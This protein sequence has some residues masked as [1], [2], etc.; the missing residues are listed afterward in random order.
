MGFGKKLSTLI[1]ATLRGGFSGRRKRPRHV[2][3]DPESQLKAIRKALAEVELKERQVGDQLQATQTRLNQAIE[4]GDQAEVTAQRRLLHQLESH[5][6]TQ[7][8][9]AVRLAESLAV[10]EDH[11]ATE[12]RE[13]AERIAA[14][15]EVRDRSAPPQ[16]SVA[17]AQSI[18]G[19]GQ[20][21][22]EPVSPAATEDA[23]DADDSQD[24]DELAARK[25][26]LSS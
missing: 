16:E 7:S 17:Q 10:I 19:A 13:A 3:D 8:T 24:D 6:K 2:P 25:S 23:T 18:G 5:L 20:A 12:R 1:N 21:Q 4:G 14:Q 15:P 22:T 11:L 26:R 9:E